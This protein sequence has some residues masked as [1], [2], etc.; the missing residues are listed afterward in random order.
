MWGSPDRGVRAAL[1]GGRGIAVLGTATAVLAVAAPAASAAAPGVLD[2]GFGGGIV[3][4]PLKTQLNAA[5]LQSDGKLVVAGLNNGIDD[6]RLLVARYLSNGQPD[7]SF[8]SGGFATAPTPAG[9][10]GAIGEDIAIQPNGNIVVAAR[11]RSVSGADGMEVV[12]YTTAG[13]LDGSFGAGGVRDL[14]LNDANN[15]FQAQAYSVVVKPGGEIVVGGQSSSGNG[16]TPTAAIMRLTGAGGVISGPHLFNNGEAAIEGLAVQGDKIVAVGHELQGQ[17]VLGFIGR[18]NADGSRD[19]SFAG[20]GVLDQNFARNGAAGSSLTDV[21]VQSGNT[22]VATGYAFDNAGGTTP[23]AFSITAKYGVNGAPDGGFGS[24]GVTYIRAAKESTV[25]TNEPGGGSVIIDDP[26]GHIYTAGNWDESGSSALLANAQT[27][28]GALDGAFGSGGSVIAPFNTYAKPAYA[29]SAA[30][31]TDGLYVVGTAG[32]T[33]QS[34]NTTTQGIIARFGA[35]AFTPP[36]PVCPDAGPALCPTG[37]PG[38]GTLAPAK[39]QL[40]SSS[41]SKGKLKLRVGATSLA[42]GVTITAKFQ[43][44]GVTSTYKVKLP[45]PS[46][47]KPVI[48]SYT[49]TLKGKQKKKT[50][51]IVTLSTPKTSKVRADELRLRVARNAAKLK[52]GTTKIAGGKL[53]VSGTVSTRATGRILFRLDYTTADGS[54]KAFNATATIKKGKWSLN[55]TLPADAAK[56]GGQ[57]A[58][59]Y[60]GNDGRRIRGEQISK[61]VTP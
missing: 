44:G 9:A 32:N 34:N 53:V 25:N 1:R 47:E 21:A 22:I 13:Q 41:I 33:P 61:A 39:L 48:K 11:I 15:N 43:S 58:I 27:G 55:A 60:T 57:L 59:Q 37:P 45:T 14:L 5:A 18:A 56:N 29:R 3:S 30:L 26:G 19:G 4:L 17:A 46:G 31:G 24:G 42:G 8:G 51:G 20:G 23:G 49:L 54:V 10:L 12:R 50:T 35:F 6:P 2:G 36:P 16:A 52:R 38:G 40:L 28:G 7:P